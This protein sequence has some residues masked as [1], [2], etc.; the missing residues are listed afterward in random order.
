[1]IEPIRTERLLLRP[2]RAPDA[3]P[4][5]FWA[6]RRE[7]AEMTPLPHPY[8]PGAAAAFIER[9][10]KGG[11]T[12]LAIDGSPSEAP[13]FLGVVGL[14]GRPGD[15]VRRL[16]FWLGPPVWG[17]GYA[18]EAAEGLLGAAFREP[19]LQAVETTVYDDN[20]ASRR[21]LEKLGFEAVGAHSALNFAR[22]EMVPE[23]V[24]R[25]ERAARRAEAAT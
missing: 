7:V 18:T 16:G 14:R 25:L 2:L 17:Y 8:P 10:G 15:A 20:P 6:G 11:E 4:M 24:M 3:G 19:S 21:V 1:M 13:V 23:T 22:G 12:H 5:A 9:A